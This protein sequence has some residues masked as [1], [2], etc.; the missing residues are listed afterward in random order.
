MQLDA[1]TF[2]LEIVNFL[3][4]LWLLKRFLYGPVQAALAAR[5]QAASAQSQAIERGRAELAAAQAEL[6]QQHQALQAQRDVAARE[7]ADELAA[8]RKKGL[9]ELSRELDAERDKARALIEQERQRASERCGQ[10]MR[11]HAA[12]FLTGYLQR[13]AS[14]AL[15]AALVELFLR[16]LQEQ[17]EQARLALRDGWAERGEGS[18][19]IEVATGHTPPDAL[20]QRVEAALGELMGEP[21]A[22]RFAWRVEAGLRAGICVHLPGHQLEASLR[23][24][25]DAFAQLS[26]DAPEVA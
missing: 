2:A 15:E 19:T 22:P 9:A 14:P 21:V 17:S 18:P 26:S 4:L 8:A 20:R 6:A 24:G 16:D 25:I 11:E 13:L 23:R 5:A 7:L 1:T 10:D 12:V 3:V